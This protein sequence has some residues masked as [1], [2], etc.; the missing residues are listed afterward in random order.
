M[1][2]YKPQS[3]SLTI[4]NRLDILEERLGE[5]LLKD[6]TLH[7]IEELSRQ[8]HILRWKKKMQHDLE[9]SILYQL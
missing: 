7:E 4:Q 9:N 6:D 5:V 8:I 2:K 1:A 3:L